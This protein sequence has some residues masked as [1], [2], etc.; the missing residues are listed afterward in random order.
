MATIDALPV[1]FR[2]RSLEPVTCSERD[3]M[4]HAP[5][6]GGAPAWLAS[7]FTYLDLDVRPGINLRAQLDAEARAGRQR[8]GPIDGG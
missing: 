2:T 4:H 3:E 7:R 5:W 1:L 8:Q 6:G